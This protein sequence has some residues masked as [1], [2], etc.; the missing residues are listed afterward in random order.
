MSNKKREAKLMAKRETAFHRTTL[1]AP[2]LQYFAH[3]LSVALLAITGCPRLFLNHRGC[4]LR[5]LLCRHTACPVPASLT[6]VKN[7]LYFSDYCSKVSRGSRKWNEKA[8]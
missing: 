7:Y 3:S 6:W 5:V 2:E 8:S 4:S 1:P